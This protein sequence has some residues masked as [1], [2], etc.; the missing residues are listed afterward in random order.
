[1]AEPGTDEPSFCHVMVLM[2]PPVDVQVREKLTD[3]AASEV[4][5]KVIGLI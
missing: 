4:S 3:G 2:G 5:A 1:M